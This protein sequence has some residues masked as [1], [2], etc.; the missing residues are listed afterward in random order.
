LLEAGAQLP[1]RVQGTDAVKAVLAAASQKQ[2]VHRRSLRAQH[3][4]H[5]SSPAASPARGAD[6]KVILE[7]SRGILL[8]D[9]PSPKV[10]RALLQAGL[11]VYGY[12][13]NRFSRAAL[14]SD[15]H[16]AA[17]ASGVFPP[18]GETE[19]D[20][21]VFHRLASRPASV[22]I[23]AVYRPAAELP[24]IIAELVLPLGATVLWLLRPLA[25]AAERQLIE[26][27]GLMLVDNCDI[28]SAALSLRPASG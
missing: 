25:S 14:V 2:G 7:S 13:P 24:G 4:G 9:W 23:V 26:G 15:L 20:Y 8:V 27:H 28:V 5:V 3:L 10:P 12:S 11:A 19:R 1:E 16:D 17:E 6:P 22:S 21:L 18:E